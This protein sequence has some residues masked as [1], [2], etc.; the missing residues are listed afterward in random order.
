MLY[1]KNAG[2]TN[3]PHLPRTVPPETFNGKLQ[4]ALQQGDTL[5]KIP[6]GIPLSEYLYEQSRQESQAAA[7]P[8]SSQSR[9]F[10]N[11]HGS[12]SPAPA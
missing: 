9:H 4:A 3:L 10:G 6:A 2:M 1:G 7:K 11:G 8:A 12:S 5:G